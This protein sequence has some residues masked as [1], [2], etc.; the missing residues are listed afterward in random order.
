[1]YPD[2]NG[3]WVKVLWGMACKTGCVWG[4]E[5]VEMACDRLTGQNWDI[6]RIGCDIWGLT[7]GV[8]AC[9]VSGRFSCGTC[10]W[11]PFLGASGWDSC[12]LCCNGGDCWYPGSTEVGDCVDELQCGDTVLAYAWGL[13]LG[14][15][16]RLGSGV[17]DEGRGSVW[18]FCGVGGLTVGSCW[19]CC[20]CDGTETERMFTP[21]VPSKLCHPY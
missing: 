16:K 19:V 18:V 2:W 12:G 14:T 20:S 4:T 21:F 7:C 10:I 13:R 1:M 11:G 15:C 8:K 6:W 9:W 3:G 5:V 17:C